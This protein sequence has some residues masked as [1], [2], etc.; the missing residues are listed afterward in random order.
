MLGSQGRRS[1]TLVEQCFFLFVTL[2]ATVS[3]RQRMY[4]KKAIT[5][6][7]FLSTRHAFGL[8]SPAVSCSSSSIPKPSVF[9]AEILSVSAN[10]TKDFEGIANNDV[11]WITVTLTHP[12]AGDR[13]NNW[14]ALPLNGWNEVFQGIGGGGYA[15]GSIGAMANQTTLGYSTVTTDA[16][17]DT[18]YSSQDASPW[19][20]LSPGNVNQDLLLNFARRS[21][22]D[23]T[24]IGK[25]ISESFYGCSIKH[26]YWNGCS[27]GGRQGMV[28][29]QYYPDDY[30]G[31]LAEA[32]A[33]QWNDFTLAQQWPY[34]V[35]NNE[36]VVLS[37]CQEEAIVIAVVNACDGLDGLVD[38]II[39]APAKCDFQ[40]QSLVGQ[41]FDCNG[42]TE[43]WTQGL[44]DVVDKIW[45]GPRT[46]EGDF[47][48]FG[49]PKGANLSDLAPNTS[50]SIAVAF[51]ISDSWIRGFVAK[52]LSYNTANVS[53][54]EFAGMVQGAALR[55]H[56]LLTTI[57][58]IFLQSHIQYDSTIGDYSPDLRPFRRSG[59]KLLTWQGLADGIINPQ[60]TML[61]YRKVQALH[62]N[63]SDF[64]RQ[65]YSPGVGHCGGGTGV[66]PTD[67]ISVLRDWV[68]RG[69]APDVLPAGSQYPGS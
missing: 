54:A 9:G 13:V 26:S 51:P 25:A 66:T 39:S 27:T 57:L 20:L 36:G 10:V 2:I 11:C 34:T 55:F 5:L 21:L 15:A 44:A 4:S 58:D 35:E 12:G 17:L 30:D 47:L 19:A 8:R 46:P 52:D 60:G 67:A 40:L 61:Y 68:E 6:V 22:H 59:G 28:M 33:I 69:K 63:L 29:A 31:I 53:Y 24:V 62:P 65:F 18:F 7:A 56:F 49:L 43:T 45:Q 38:G 23:M 14:I 42:T 50:G 16:G 48:W 41:Q 37:P 1:L 3:T 32:P 64:Y